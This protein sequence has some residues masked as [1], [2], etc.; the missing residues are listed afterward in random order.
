MLKSKLRL[1]CE[2]ALR[3]GGYREKSREWH[4]SHERRQRAARFARNLK[5]RAFVQAKQR[6]IAPQ[7][8]K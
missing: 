2:Q 7:R 5:C 6:A 8:E 3:V 1:A 4:A